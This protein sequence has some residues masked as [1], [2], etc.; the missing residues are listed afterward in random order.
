[1]TVTR[2]LPDHRAA[3][4]VVVEVSGGRFASLP[5]EMVRALGLREGMQLDDAQAERLRASAEAEAAYRVATN[6]LAV[7]ARSSGEL[8]RKLRERGHD[9]RAIRV[10]LDRLQASG[11]LD[12]AA[13]SRH[14]AAGRL[15]KGHGS[16]RVLTDLLARGVERRVAELAVREAGRDEGIRAADQVER[17]I[18]RRAALGR[19]LAVGVRRRR[20]LSY[21]A[22]RGFRGSRV[23]ELVERALVDG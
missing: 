18:Q 12:D 11:A 15:V 23:R 20:L 19:S 13:F 21:L 22:R 6:L 8:E 10:A 16:A 17:L 1:V 2:L 9:A 3:G 14:F 7:R 5:V 4:C